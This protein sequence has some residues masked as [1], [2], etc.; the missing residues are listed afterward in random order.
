MPSNLQSRLKLPCGAT[1]KNR[2]AKAAMTEGLADA[3]GVPTKALENLYGLWSDGGAGTLLTGNIIIDRDHL[4]RPGNVIIHGEP[5]AKLAVAL[6]SWAKTATRNGNALWAQLSHGG[7][8]VMKIVNPNPKAASP[9]QLGLPGGQFGE[10][11][12]LTGEEIA[13]LVEQ[14]NKRNL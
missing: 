8:Q 14:R 2:I 10:P 4:E 5:N 9:V 13:E 7:R 11:V 6:K 1:L 3:Y 12:A